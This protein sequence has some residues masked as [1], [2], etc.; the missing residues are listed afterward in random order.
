MTPRAAGWLLALGTLL[1][2]VTSLAVGLPASDVGVLVGVA[3]GAA[4]A[5]GVTGALVLRAV[6]RSAFVTQISVVALTATAAAS[7]GSLA[8]AQAMFFSTHDLGVLWVVMAVA[9]LVG[10]C[11]ALV[12]GHRLAAASRSLGEATRLLG[13]GAMVQQDER[14]G[15]AEFSDLGRQLHETADRL[16]G[17][18]VAEQAADRS[19]RELTAWMSHDLRTP[20]AGI[21]AIAEALEDGVVTDADVVRRYHQT[22]RGEA[23]RLTG[24]VDGLFELSRISAGVTSTDEQ[25]VSL[26]D[27]VSDAIASAAPVAEAGGVTL[28]GRLVE[29]DAE[30]SVSVPE[31]QR[32]LGNV[33]GN[34]LRET[35]RGG[36]ISV[37]TGAAPEGGY[38]SVRD[39]CGG[40]PDQDLPRVFDPAYRGSLARTPATRCGSGTRAGD[41]A[42][43]AGGPRRHHHRPQQRRRLRVLPPAP[44]APRHR[45]GRVSR[46][47]RRQHGWRSRPVLRSHTRRQRS[48]LAA[49]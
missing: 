4:L 37:E 1:I 21:R 29:P 18:R 38:V 40:I 2:A 45:A 17:A 31:I 23:D 34:A 8:A 11:T 24:L 15:I 30:V 25:R 42:G 22:L 41:R 7:A 43:P 36:A 10:V 49:A 13:D 12:L 9:A 46:G 47:P 28:A 32:V 44:A 39:E 35:P 33:I 19:R 27:L 5:V 6:R 26:G 20:L 3:G 16:H 14:G 48:A